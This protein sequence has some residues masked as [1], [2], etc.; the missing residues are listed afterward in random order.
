MINLRFGNGH[1][2]MPCRNEIGSASSSYCFKMALLRPDNSRR[3]PSC[4]LAVEL[5]GP[6]WW[7]D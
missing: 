2:R 6:G 5:D 4:G 7:V 3:V 1:S